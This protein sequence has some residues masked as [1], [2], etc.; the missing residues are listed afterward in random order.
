MARSLAGELR[1]LGREKLA[2]L[3]L[4]DVMAAEGRWQEAT[5]VWA[6]HQGLDFALRRARVA[7]HAGTADLAVEMLINVPLRERSPEDSI[8]Y[9]LALVETG[10]RTAAFEILSSQDGE[11]NTAASVLLPFFRYSLFGSD[12]REGLARGDRQA[13]RRALDE[14]RRCLEVDG[15]LTVVA[16]LLHWSNGNIVGL[17]PLD[18][19]PLRQAIFLRITRPLP[20][21][22]AG[23]RKAWLGDRD[24]AARSF[25]TYLSLLPEPD[26]RSRALVFLAGE[27]MDAQEDSGPAASD[28]ASRSD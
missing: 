22:Y 18:Q 9:A 1:S 21:Y 23:V 10:R 25:R 8:I 28:R 14:I 24:A 15:C 6:R 17:E 26:E 16:E 13:F 2:D 19:E 11:P 12:D 27:N 7:F 4:G 20:H 5:E 3:Y